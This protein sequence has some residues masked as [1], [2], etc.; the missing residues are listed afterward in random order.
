MVNADT[1]GSVDAVAGQASDAGASSA[2][3]AVA[4]RMTARKV[5][6]WYAEKQALYDVDLDIPD[7]QVTALIGPSGCG[8]STFLRCL[9]RMNDTI[10]IC[11]V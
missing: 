1:I 8:K 6:L 11:R 7:R 3:A 5:N 4:N 10:D 2:S 9:N